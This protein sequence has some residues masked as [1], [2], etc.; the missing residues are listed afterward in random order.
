LSHASHNIIITLYKSLLIKFKICLSIRGTHITS[1]RDWMVV[2]SCEGCEVPITRRS[3]ARCL[4]RRL[5]NARQQWSA[6]QTRERKLTLDGRFLAIYRNDKR[7]V[8]RSPAGRDGASV[9]IT[10]GSSNDFTI[11]THGGGAVCFCAWL[12]APAG[13]RP[14]FFTE[15]I[16]D[17]AEFGRIYCHMPRNLA[18]L[19]RIS[20]SC[21]D[22]LLAVQV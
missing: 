22:T 5:A 3:V 10:P 13:I 6:I 14:A 17:A 2:Y 11:V 8:E 7:R 21:N 9:F 4:R 1:A 15:V 12:S 16:C 20:A 18:M 19:W